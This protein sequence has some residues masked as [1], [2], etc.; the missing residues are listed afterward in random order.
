MADYPDSVALKSGGTDDGKIVVAGAFGI[1][2][3]NA[4]GTLDHDFGNSGIMNQPDNSGTAVAILANDDIVVAGTDADNFAL[5]IYEPSG[6][7]CA[8]SRGR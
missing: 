2:Q 4:N 1:A 3:I 7:R 5:A 6:Q 8:S